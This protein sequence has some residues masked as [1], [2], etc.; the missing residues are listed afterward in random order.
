M[1]KSV[2]S[3]GLGAQAEGR[4]KGPYTLRQSCPL[5]ILHPL[6]SQPQGFIFFDDLCPCSWGETFLCQEMNC[7]HLSLIAP[8]P[9]PGCTHN[10]GAG[11]REAKAPAR[12]AALIMAPFARS[13]SVVANNLIKKSTAFLRNWRRFVLGFCVLF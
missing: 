2:T 11:G 7:H 5:K 6:I 13:T 4:A 9:T 3:P 12:G 8:P 10:R 1:S